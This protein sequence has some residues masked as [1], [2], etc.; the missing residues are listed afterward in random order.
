MQGIIV[1]ILFAL[2]ACGGGGGGDDGGDDGGDGGDGGVDPAPVVAAASLTT[3]ED[4]PIAHTVEASDP[5]GRALTLEARPPL[6]GAVT[7]DRLRVTYTPV[8]NYHGPDSF[9]VTV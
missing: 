4:A 7:V 9:T 3:D 6:H 8:A 5:K 1:G 2:V